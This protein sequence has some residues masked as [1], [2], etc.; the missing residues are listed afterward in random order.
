MSDETTAAPAA[1][2]APN[3]VAQA[4]EAVVAAAA[5]AV[6]GA[7]TAEAVL[8]ETPTPEAPKDD[9]FAAKFAALSKREKALRQQEAAMKKRF[10]DMEAKFKAQEESLKPFRNLQESASK[11][12]GVLWDNLKAA[13]LTEQQII[14][15]HI[16]KQEPTAEEKQLS[17][18][19]QVQEEI[20]ALKAER[21]RE[22][23]E[24]KQKD[25]DAQ[26]R[27][28]AQ[29]K[30]NYVKY[31]KDFVAKNAE[32]YELIRANDAVD[33]V[34]EVIEEHYNLTETEHG[35]GKGV[36]LS[37]KDAA[38]RVEDYLLEQAKKMIE[39][40]KLRQLVGAQKPTPAPSKGQS[41]TLSNSNAQVVPSKA[42]PYLSDS[43]SKRKMAAM[44]KFT[45]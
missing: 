44:I 9:K 41:A 42:E 6:P 22:K 19:Q 21:E 31:L 26:K 15:R 35:A 18:V 34:Y 27:R 40:N 20:K 8:P 25:A 13:G 4:L 12:P 29:T 28:E 43:E 33:L 2:D 3:E 32:T 1:A 7:E 14:E 38:D 10:S 17:M 24:A 11:D 36:V 39:S 45:S 30:E 37:E 16:L 5:E 23:E